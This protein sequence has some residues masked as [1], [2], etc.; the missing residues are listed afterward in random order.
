MQ[1]DS[2][3]SGTDSND[4]KEVV[5][6]VIIHPHFLHP[7]LIEHAYHR[8]QSSSTCLNLPRLDAASV[9]TKQF[10]QRLFEEI[11]SQSNPVT[12]AL[13]IPERLVVNITTHICI[14]NIETSRLV[15]DV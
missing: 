6:V 1:E 14:D 11:P 12:D 10:F 2:D 4:E 9:S 3:T 8:S 15:S 7:S 5:D 13:C